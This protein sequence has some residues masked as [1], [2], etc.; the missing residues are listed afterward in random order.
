LKGRISFTAVCAR[1]EDILDG[2]SRRRILEG[3][4]ASSL[5]AAFRA[6]ELSLAGAVASLDARTRQDGFHI[7]NDWDGKA[8]RFNEETIPEEVARFASERGVPSDPALLAILL[9][10]YLLYLL[11]LVALRA[12][13]EGDPDENLDRVDA[14]LQG[15]Q[16]AAGSGQKFV[17]HAM[18]LILLAVSHFEPDVS[19]Y[20]RLL[21]KVK[22]LDERHRLRLALASASI[23]SSHLRFGFEATYGRDVLEMRRDNVPDYPWLLFALDTLMARYDRL[24]EESIPSHERD[25]VVEG[26]L[27]GLTPDPRAF[28]GTPPASL[29]GFDPERSRFLALFGKHRSLFLDE[30]E[31]LRPTEMTYS[32]LSFFFNFPHNLLKGIVIDG[33][34]RRKPW[35]ISLDD[36]LTGGPRESEDKKKLAE[37][38][39]GYARMSP[40]RIRGKLTPAIVYDPRAGRRLF[41]DA[42][43]RLRE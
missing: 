10:Y 14:M 9:D 41:G 4:S 32:P 38:M 25:R 43:R 19:A 28:V 35:R 12:W 24:A 34:L 33:V 7:L 18:T 30:I 21:A 16:G 20:D 36:L 23:L 37:T 26:L 17:D 29:A 5:R 6:N 1:L 27:S 15:L 42:L 2:A 22:S 13:D 8:D 3:A 31:A 39:M 40:D 11:A